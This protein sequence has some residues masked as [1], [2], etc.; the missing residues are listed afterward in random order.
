MYWYKCKD[1]KKTMF[2]GDE[3]VR[4]DPYSYFGGENIEK[5]GHR[6]DIDFTID[7]CFPEIKEDDWWD[8]WN[9]EDKE[10]EKDDSLNGE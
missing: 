5:W 10:D 6:S 8:E 3:M 4:S 1:N 2:I 7:I 9:W